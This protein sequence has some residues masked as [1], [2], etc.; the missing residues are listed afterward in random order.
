M[1][2]DEAETSFWDKYSH[3]PSDSS[4]NSGKSEFDLNRMPYI[5]YDGSNNEW[6]RQYFNSREVVY[7]DK[8][9]GRR[10]TIYSGQISG[11]SARTSA[12]HFHWY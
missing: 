2:D 12:G 5:I 7:K 1:V 10:V 6:R 4:R 11:S 8:E 3:S 9:T